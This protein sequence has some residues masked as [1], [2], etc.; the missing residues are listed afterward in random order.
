MTIDKLENLLHL[1]GW[2]S[3]KHFTI[4]SAKKKGPKLWLYNLH[5]TFIGEWPL[6]CSPTTHNVTQSFLIFLNTRH[7]ALSENIIFFTEWLPLSGGYSR[8]IET[9][10]QS[11][12]Q[13]D[14]QHQSSICISFVFNIKVGEVINLHSSCILSNL[15]QLNARIVKHSFF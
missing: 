1:V 7:V 12:V 5:Q 13:S 4:F 10:T 2:F 8:D 3:W 14:T 6:W 11:S 15:I 9:F